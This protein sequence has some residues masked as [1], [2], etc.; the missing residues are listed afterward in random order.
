MKGLLLAIVVVQLVCHA[1]RTGLNIYEM[2]MVRKNRII[3]FILVFALVQ[4]F[5][6]YPVYLDEPWLIDV[7]HLLLV[8]AAS[9]NVVIVAV[10][11]GAK[12]RNDGG[13]WILSS[14]LIAAEDRILLLW[15]TW[16]LSAIY[17]DLHISKKMPTESLRTHGF[18]TFYCLTRSRLLG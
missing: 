5:Q 10:Q 18:E 4:A 3:R 15:H 14:H 13:P 16:K 12:S 2:V 9:C 7:S 11:V 1:P 17:I 8:V 6:G